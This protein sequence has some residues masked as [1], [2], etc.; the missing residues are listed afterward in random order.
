MTEYTSYYFQTSLELLLKS[1][2]KN[3]TN[4]NLKRKKLK[5]RDGWKINLM[6]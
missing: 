1:V 3:K 5:S 2:K 4:W 6:L